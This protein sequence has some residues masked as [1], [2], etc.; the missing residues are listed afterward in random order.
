C[1]DVQGVS[2]QQGLTQVQ[3]QMIGKIMKTEHLKIS[4]VGEGIMVI[5]KMMTSKLI[6]LILDYVDD[7]EQFDA[8]A[9]SPTWFCPGSLIIFTSKD[10]QLLSSHRVD[11]IY[12][13]E[14][15]DDYKALELFS[16]YASGKRSLM[17][18]FKDLASRVVKHLQGHPLDLKRRESR[19]FAAS[20]LDSTQCS[21]NA[22]IEVLAD[23]FL[24]TVSKDLL[25]MHELIQSMEAAFVKMSKESH[26]NKA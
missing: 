16:L 3:M 22:I 19:Y 9:G 10:K 25:Q 20:V 23:K 21:A 1:K 13:M 6:L 18:V 12:K 2:Q 14:S 26:N 17:E 8:L 5:R 7:H 15:L 24:I 11:K 4:S